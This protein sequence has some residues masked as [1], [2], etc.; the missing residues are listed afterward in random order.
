[1]IVDLEISG[2]MIFF[3]K[4]TLDQHYKKIPF[5]IHQRKLIGWMELS[6]RIAFLDKN[7]TS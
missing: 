4:S 7:F 6:G 2:N 3:S 1:M 5:K